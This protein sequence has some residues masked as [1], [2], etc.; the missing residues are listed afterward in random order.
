MFSVLSGSFF[1]FLFIFHIAIVHSNITKPVLDIY[2][3]KT[4]PSNKPSNIKRIYR[5]LHTL[6]QKTIIWGNKVKTCTRAQPM[7]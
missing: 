2:E 1:F 3:D 7:H 5:N 4:P 6:L